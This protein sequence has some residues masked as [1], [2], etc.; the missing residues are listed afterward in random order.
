MSSSF[1]LKLYTKLEQKI[2]KLEFCEKLFF[3]IIFT[4]VNKENKTRILGTNI[5]MK[6]LRKRIINV[7]KKCTD[8]L[9]GYF[10]LKVD[11]IYF[12]KGIPTVAIAVEMLIVKA[13]RAKIIAIS[14]VPGIFFLSIIT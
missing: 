14:L 1:S 4:S 7:T 2:Q 8:V 12:R 9:T 6:K 10:A 5:A 13:I 3:E 11:Q